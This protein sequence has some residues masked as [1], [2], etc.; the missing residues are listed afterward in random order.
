MQGFVGHCRDFGFSWV[1]D[2]S[3]RRIQ[4]RRGTDLPLAVCGEQMGGRGAGVRGRE[5]REEA[6]AVS[7]V[8]SWWLGP[9]QRLWRW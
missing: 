2:R 7:L 1:N 4:N 6:F 3:N 8:R 9:G 5:P